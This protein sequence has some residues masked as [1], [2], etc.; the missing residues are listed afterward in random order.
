MP[1]W[2]LMTYLCQPAPGKVLPG[3]TLGGACISPTKLFQR[4]TNTV[5]TYTY[6]NCGRLISITFTGPTQSIT[7]TYDTAGNRV[8][9]VTA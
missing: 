5:T 2:L 7:I 1:N 4:S 9:V 3:A 8:S 6:D